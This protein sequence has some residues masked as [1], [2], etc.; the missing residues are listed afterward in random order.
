MNPITFMELG[1]VSGLSDPSD[2]AIDAAEPSLCTERG[3]S[4]TSPHGVV[5]AQCGLLSREVGR[6]VGVDETTCRICICHGPADPAQNAALRKHIVQ[7]AFSA[8]IAGVDAA[9]PLAPSD[10]NLDIAVANVKGHGG[11]DIAR[12]FIDALVYHQSVTPE[13][14]VA[15][16][17][18]H[19]LSGSSP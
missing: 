11:G 7:C 17:E 5:T 18:A 19:D 14:A 2:A 1:Q 4:H 12:R 10:A 9:Q 15:L 16:L 13:K 3:G 6:P 8:T